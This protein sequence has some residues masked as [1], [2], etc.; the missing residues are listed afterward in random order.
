MSA[1]DDLQQQMVQWNDTVAA[2]GIQ[3]ILNNPTAVTQMET[4]TLD[5]ASLNTTV[6]QALGVQPVQLGE[7]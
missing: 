5:M 2:A 6:Q 4:A 7:L 3:A 1:Y